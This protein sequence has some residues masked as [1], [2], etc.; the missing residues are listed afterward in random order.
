MTLPNPLLRIATQGMVGIAY[1][2]RSYQI[3]G[4]QVAHVVY[5]GIG[6]W[7]DCPVVGD[8]N[9]AIKAP[10]EAFTG[11]LDPAKH[12]QVVIA[13]REA[14][15]SPIVLDLV[16]NPDIKLQDTTDIDEYHAGD[17]KDPDGTTKTTDTVF[18]NGGSTLALNADGSVEVAPNKQMTLALNEDPLR[19]SKGGESGDSIPG[20]NTT[21]DQFNAAINALNAATARLKVVEEALTVGIV[22]LL[23]VIT[24]VLPPNFKLKLPDIAVQEIQARLTAILP[25]GAPEITLERQDGG[26]DAPTNILELMGLKDTP[27]LTLQFVAPTSGDALAAPGI[28]IPSK[29]A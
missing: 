22:D 27:D 25:E 10:N 8:H 24:A 13:F 15:R 18:A 1:A 2:V 11:V 26:Q 20:A 14:K 9:K 19:I 17:Q 23:S 4:M 21:A 28:T 5:P 3:K 12:P 6:S 29:G 16:S 7:E